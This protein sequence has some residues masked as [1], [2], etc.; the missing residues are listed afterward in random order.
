MVAGI[1]DVYRFA[2]FIGRFL[3]IIFYTSSP[4][5]NKFL[6]V[7]WIHDFFSWSFK[8]TNWNGLKN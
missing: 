7:E 6:Q 1:L 4:V 2:Y 3:Q 8:K 5:V